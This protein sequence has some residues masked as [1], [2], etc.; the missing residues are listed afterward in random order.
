MGLLRSCVLYR[1]TKAG[2]YR[3][4][5]FEIGKKHPVCGP[6]LKKNLRSQAYLRPGKKCG[7][8]TK[9]QTRRQRR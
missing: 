4:A 7:P 3:C 8:A 2:V 9:K 6:M 5:E 1:R